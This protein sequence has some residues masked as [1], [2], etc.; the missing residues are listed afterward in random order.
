VRSDPDGVTRPDRILKFNEAFSSA[1]LYNARMGDKSPVARG[2]GASF[3][4]PN[5]FGG[6][7]HVLD[8]EQVEQD[9]EYLATLQNPLTEYLPDQSR[10]VVTENSSPDVGFRFSL[11][12]YR[13]CLHGCAYCYARPTH[14]YLGLGA[15]LDFE[16]KIFFKQDAPDLFRDFLARD[17]WEPEPIA[18]SGVTDP[19]QPAEKQF[20][21]TCRCLEV[22]AEANQPVSLITKNALVLRDL[23]L[24]AGMGRLGLVHANISVTTLDPELARSMEPRTSTPAARLRAVRELSAAGIP[25]RVL[26]APVIPGLNDSEIPAILAA[27]SAAGARAAGFIMLRLPLAVTPIFL[28]WLERT[29]PEMRRRIEGRIRDVRGGKLNDAVFGRRMTGSG[30][31]A[32]QI[33][34]LFRLFA[35]R[36]GL[37]GDLPP[38]DC[39]HFRPPRDRA[40]QGRLF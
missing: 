29:R 8:L 18:L 37:D 16:R 30:E 19:Y 10:T 5:R 15:G 25:V 39:T 9:E 12:P 32:E 35:R 20:R 33:R 40:G 21:L 36:H 22:A 7:I 38:Y 34:K 11:N 26:V 27:A 31:L 4:P 14:E 24:L 1:A 2:R 6:L 3:N 23:D 13:G 28:E 17:G